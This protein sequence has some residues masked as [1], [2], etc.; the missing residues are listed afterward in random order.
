MNNESKPFGPLISAQALH[1]C[2]SE[3]DL[4]VVDAT[5]IAPFLDPDT[6]GVELYN[7]A[8]IPGAVF[9]DI[10]LVA[11]Q[12][13][14]LPHM[15]PP[16]GQF[17]EQVGAMGIDERSRIVCYDQNNYFAAPRAWWMFRMMGFENVA[18]LDGGFDAWK[19]IDGSIDATDAVT[20]DPSEVKTAFN[21]QL[22]ISLSELK[23]AVETQSHF[24]LD[25]R[26]PARFKAEAPEPRAGLKGGHMP[27]AYNIPPTLLIDE[28]GEMKSPEEIRA[29]FESAGVNLDAPI[30]TTCGSGVTAAILSLALAAIGRN[31]VALYDGSWSEWGAQD[32]CPC[33][34]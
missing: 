7:Q 16:V 30:V 18:V 3:P 6:K 29:E 1:S 31:D 8:R 4:K 9:L 32:D 10:D 23:R 15:A 14:T 2:L 22:L 12:S 19:S 34:S 33:V 24:V 26:P 28:Q 25:A 5:W 27:G 17:A 11:D 21:S 20:P 13:S